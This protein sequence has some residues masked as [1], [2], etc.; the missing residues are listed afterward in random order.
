MASTASL[1]PQQSHQPPPPASMSPD[2]PPPQT[3][4]SLSS[5]QN[6][7]TD[8]DSEQ[9][10]QYSNS[11]S[12]QQRMDQF[13]SMT[14]AA[15]AAAAANNRMS[16]S[17]KRGNHHNNNP[18]EQG[19][20][21]SYQY[22]DASAT[23]GSNS[24]DEDDGESHQ[25]AESEI[26]GG[27]EGGNGKRG[28]GHFNGYSS[29]KKRRKQSKPIRLSAGDAQ[30]LPQKDLPEEDRSPSEARR[31]SEEE[32]LEEGERVPRGQ[33][34]DE[35]E[36]EEGARADGPLN[37]SATSSKDPD[38][39]DGEEEGEVVRNGTNRTG[40]L[41]PSLRVLGAE[42]MQSNGPE[43]LTGL[44]IPPGLSA[45]QASS[46]P[47]SLYQGMLQ[48]GLPPFPFP[49]PLTSQAGGQPG[50]PSSLSGKI[51]PTSIPMSSSSSSAPPLSAGGRVQ[52]F[53]P[54]AYCE[55]CNKEFCNKYFLKTHKANKHGIYSESG[56][57]NGAGGAGA[58][59]SS[60]P[61]GGPNLQNSSSPGPGRGG[62]DGNTAGPPTPNSQPGGERGSPFSGAF[63]AANMGSLRPPFLPL[64]PGASPSP[65]S[66]G[67]L[68]NSS[69]GGVNPSSIGKEFASKDHGTLKRDA[70]SRGSEAGDREQASSPISSSASLTPRSSMPHG[71]I[72]G[73]PPSSQPNAAAA[74]AAAA[75]MFSPGGTPIG[76]I[77]DFRQSA[78]DRERLM[79][80]QYFDKEIGELQRSIERGSPRASLS[81]LTSGAFNPLLFGGIPSMDSLKKQEEGIRRDIGGRPSM[82]SE[83]GS[84]PN[85]PNLTSPSGRT[86]H[87]PK[88]PFTPEKLRQMGVINADAFCEICCKEFCN[89]YFLRVHKLKKHGICSPDLPPEKVSVYDNMRWISNFSMNYTYNRA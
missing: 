30:S 5:P 51:P 66:T 41:Q 27:A 31:Y 12:L 7:S 70:P 42:L 25:D 48:F 88:G 20:G 17:T 18:S 8:H 44:K 29:S 62:P 82:S 85:I 36:Y 67:N 39:V 76:G 54:E 58:P 81:Q 64:S 43:S 56:G 47:T 69:N 40:G 11:V 9:T 79:G 55:L 4:S 33:R 14:T 74:A 15:A 2:T 80:R 75:M 32:E 26:S 16:S 21:E 38:L 22:Q 89:K 35:E 3:K 65:T 78:E 83:S 1:Q 68:P 63:I 73:L 60:S 46:I 61:G 10:D 59:R 13:L 77:P 52:I 84:M 71:V 86:G 45:Q 23:S 50:T 37:L 49:F 72:P 34:D 57:G 6:I 24:A 28:R 53:N 87:E 19:I